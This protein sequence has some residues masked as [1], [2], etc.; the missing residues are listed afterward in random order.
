MAHVLIR[1][2]SSPGGTGGYVADA[3]A[4]YENQAF[5][6]DCGKS[7]FS[8]K[9]IIHLVYPSKSCITNF[10]SVLLSSEKKSKTMVMHQFFFF[11]RGGGE[12]CKQSAVWS[13]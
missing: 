3:S 2:G 12:G 1:P 11:G 8:H 13:L 10:S 5:D 9:T 7:P 6:G 4:A